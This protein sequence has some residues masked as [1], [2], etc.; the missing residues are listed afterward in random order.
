MSSDTVVLRVNIGCLD[1]SNIGQTI[2]RVHHWDKPIWEIAKASRPTLVRRL[3]AWR[4]RRSIGGDLST[5][6]VSIRQSERQWMQE[7]I[8]RRQEILGCSGRNRQLWCRHTVRWNYGA[9]EME[10]SGGALRASADAVPYVSPRTEHRLCWP[11]HDCSGQPRPETK[12]ALTLL[13]FSICNG[14]LA[15]LRQFT[16]DR[17]R[18]S[19]VKLR[20]RTNL[21]TLNTIIAVAPE[22]LT[23]RTFVVDTEY[24][25][26]LITNRTWREPV[27]W[28]RQMCSNPECGYTMPPERARISHSVADSRVTRCRH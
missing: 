25:T 28:P 23:F 27:A 15:T 24:V 11:G 1:K 16:L 7:R 12:G 8:F 17:Q 13:R 14:Y 3:Y 18:P 21:I 2:A 9:K 10:N 5:S 26:G 22:I 20:W 4:R 19:S 6:M